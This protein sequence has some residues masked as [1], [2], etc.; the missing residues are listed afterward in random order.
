MPNFEFLN[1]SSASPT[2]VI[3]LILQNGQVLAAKLWSDDVKNIENKDGTKPYKEIIESV[4]YERKIYENQIKPILDEDNTLPF[5][6]YVGEGCKS[7]AEDLAKFFRVNI[8]DGFELMYFFGALYFYIENPGM[9]FHY[10]KKV[11]LDYM[12]KKQLAIHNILDGFK[13]KNTLFHCILLPF[14]NNAQT[15][16][17]YIEN[18]NTYTLLQKVVDITLGIQTLFNNK[19]VHNDLHSNNIMITNNKVLMFDWDRAYSVNIGNNPMLNNDPCNNMCASSQC[20]IVTE[21]STDFFKMFSYMASRPDF[22]I[23]LEKFGIYN[24]EREPDKLVKIRNFFLNSARSYFSKKNDV[25]KK[26]CTY[27]Q[28]PNEDMKEIIKLFD[29]GDINKI[30]ERVSKPDFI[31]IDLIQDYFRFTSKESEKIENIKEYQ[32]LEQKMSTFKDEFNYKN[33][34][35][36]KDNNE[37]KER[38]NKIIK[39]DVKPIIKSRPM[40]GKNIFE[41][42]EENNIRKYGFGKT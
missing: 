24:T 28:F 29:D 41:I 3:K 30:Y 12:D 8:R 14:V 31:K 27:L 37:T 19:T 33:I 26:R 9:P 20:N 25:N 42:I 35:I 39:T 22:P 7:S 21:H 2:I 5:L 1:K 34:K 16:A 32:P 40:R 4:E 11:V 17:D 38:I 23:I 15:F 18:A 10:Q 6:P 13:R 36:I